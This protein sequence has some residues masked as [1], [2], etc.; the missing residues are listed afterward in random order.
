MA[1]ALPLSLLIVACDPGK[2]IRQA[3]S[4][5]EVSKHSSVILQIK[6]THELIGTTI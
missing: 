1:F 3:H 4:P 2:T 6:S 5:D